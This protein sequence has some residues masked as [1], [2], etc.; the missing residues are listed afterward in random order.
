M[1]ASILLLTA[2]LALALRP[3]YGLQLHSFNDLRAVPQAFAKI[4]PQPS[5]VLLKLDPQYLPP[6][7]CALQQRAPTPPDARGCLMLNH[8]AVTRSAR[9]TLNSS[10]DLL[11]LL[12]DPALARYT[13]SAASPLVLSLCFKGC[14]GALGCPCDASA[15]TAAW[16]SLVDEL[17]AALQRAAAAARGG[18]RVVLDGAANPGAAACL[19]QRWRPL[20]S[21]FI[22]GD[23]PAS[24]FLS[25]AT[26]Q[27]FD[28]LLTL[29]EPLDA[30]QTAAALGFGKFAAGARPYVMWE[31]SD[32]AGMAAAAR[33]YAARLAAGHPP[34]APG[35]LWAVNTD[36]AQYAVYLAGEGARGVNLA[37]P[38]NGSGPLAPPPGA[39]PRA[40]LLASALH[41]AAAGAGAPPQRL[42]LALWQE[43]LPAAPAPAAAAAAAAAP[44]PY[45]ALLHAAAN[46]TWGG[47]AAL[48]L[49]APPAPLPLP[50][51]AAPFANATAAPPS[52]SLLT[53]PNATTL[54]LVQLGAAGA[55]AYALPPSGAPGG[56]AL[57]AAGALWLPAAPGAPEAGSALAPAVA[58]CSDCL[59][60]GSG[61]LARF[62]LFA[63]RA[64]SNCSLALSLGAVD[65]GGGSGGRGLNASSLTLC[66]VAAQG[67]AWQGGLGSLSLAAASYAAASGAPR[68]GV[69][70][71]Y[72]TQGGTYIATA[73]AAP[74]SAPWE[75]W[76]A[77]DAAVNSP[78]ACFPEQLRGAGGAGGGGVLPAAQWRQRQGSTAPLALLA[79]GDVAVAAYSLPA[80]SGGG[81]QA[82]L[83][84]GASACLNS[85][86]R[87]K[88]AGI[89]LCEA[90]LAPPRGS[91][92]L[93]YAAGTL[94]HLGVVVGGGEGG[95]GAG[96]GLHCSRLVAGGSAG[97]GA[98][99]GVG[100]W[101]AEGGAGGGGAQAVLA[102]EG[103]GAGAGDPLAC[104]AAGAGAAG[105]V[106]L[107]A[108]P[109]AQPAPW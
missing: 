68:V 100:A 24:A 50:P 1:R 9:A 83:A 49:A 97:Q 90:P 76:L 19:A 32:A 14:G 72:A 36:P 51:P 61:A 98:R 30:F 58:F 96:L 38:R 105:Q 73:C 34:H 12:A 64:G 5:G 86:A 54:A 77:A 107:L 93:A 15:Q 10:A 99:P 35:M 4:A 88:A 16:L 78:L 17:L 23:D 26:A 3:E 7:L 43:T 20:E 65:V 28:R 109:Q 60:G 39:T 40:P 22:S 85:E 31:P 57:S 91:Q 47:Q 13:A 44:L 81:V 11:A 74:P 25:N 69:I 82:V 21:V 84:V 87:N 56:S 70:A 8:D 55:L 108:W 71:A 6:E 75:P 48:A 92:Y 67:A 79:G 46:S 37:L 52:L 33:A 42:L 53:L 104:G 89:A 63:P 62:A 102:V 66:L 27:G 94:A 103:A 95:G 106:Q 59:G 18:L 80:S 101:W 45:Y 2:S 29:N 41:H